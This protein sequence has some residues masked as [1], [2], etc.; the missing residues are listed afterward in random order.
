[1]KKQ[2]TKVMEPME[3][4]PQDAKNV[5]GPNQ[6]EAQKQVEPSFLLNA[7]EPKGQIN[8]TEQLSTPGAH[9]KFKAS[10]MQSLMN[11]G[12]QESNLPT[13]AHTNALGSSANFQRKFNTK[14]F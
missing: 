2:T 5:P 14:A 4:T 9:K 12:N 11:S 7:L 8:K 1:M 10:Q 3:P 13:M 6:T